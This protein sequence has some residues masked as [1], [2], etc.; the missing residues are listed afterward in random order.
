LIAAFS[1]VVI[2]LLVMGP[3]LWERLQALARR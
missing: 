2:G 1:A 3:P